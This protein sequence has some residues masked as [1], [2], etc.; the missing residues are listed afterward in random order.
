MPL[1]GRTS[2]PPPVVRS[3][4]S[5]SAH[6][7]HE[8]LH[9]H[10]EQ[11]AR[12]VEA[13]ARPVRAAARERIEHR[14]AQARRR[15]QAVVAQPGERSRHAARCSGVGAR[16]R[17]RS[18]RCGTSGGGAL[19][20]GCVGHARSPG[21]SLAGT[22]RSSTGNSGAPVAR[23]STNTKPCLVACT[24]A[25]T[26]RAVALEGHEHGRRGEVVVPEI[27]VDG[28]EVPDAPSARGVERDHRIAEQIRAR[29]VA[30][31]E[32]GARR[33][34]GQEQPAAREVGGDRRPHV[35]GARESGV[36]FPGLATDLALVRNRVERP[37]QRARA[38]VE[39]AHVAGRRVGAQRV[40]DRRAHAITS[41]TTVPGEVTLYSRG[42]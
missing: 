31:V 41:P 21:T 16:G 42:S 37:A 40:G 35:R 5:S 18:R 27:V 15:E 32:V 23:S 19:G 39:R 7:V 28:L 9:R 25:S 22:G 8:V 33:G 34:D 26:G 36:A 1:S 13:R 14:A 24:T 2:L 11:P 17:P 3:P 4:T 10:D 38:H 20:T 6:D 29:A 12:G 30:A